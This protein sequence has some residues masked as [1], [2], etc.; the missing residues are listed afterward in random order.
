MSNI[1]TLLRAHLDAEPDP[2]AVVL[3]AE[4]CAAPVRDEVDLAAKLAMFLILAGPQDEATSPTERAL[5]ASTT[6]GLKKF[7]ADPFALLTAAQK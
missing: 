6:A 7:Y 1:C 2:R 4:A 5:I 3:W